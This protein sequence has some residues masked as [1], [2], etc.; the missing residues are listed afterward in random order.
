VDF[1]YIAVMKLYIAAA[2]IIEIEP[3]IE[4]PLIQDHQLVITGVGSVSTV[5]HLTKII[6]DQ[7]P[8]L[9]IQAGVAGGFDT[10]LELGEVL[11]VKRDRL[12]D[13]GVEEKG[14]WKDLVDLGLAHENDTPFNDGWLVN[15]NKEMG[16]YGLPTVD[17]ITISEITTNERRIRILNEKY[18]PA[19]ESMEGAAF[20]FV[21]LQENIPFVQLRAVSNYVGE[22][23]KSKWKMDLAIKNLNLELAKII[24][25]SK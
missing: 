13:L 15:E 22:R 17:A 8:D 16:K 10:R 5:Y 9:I 21:C 1:L 12:A 7:K 6:K 20:H 25:Q 2:T 19:A 24:E 23:D 3:L 14:E 18:H 11:M 4:T